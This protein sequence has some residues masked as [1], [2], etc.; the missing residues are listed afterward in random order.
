MGT[1]VCAYMHMLT[2]C[3]TLTVNL[4]GE[5][6][7]LA[8]HEVFDGVAGVAFLWSLTLVLQGMRIGEIKQWEIDCVSQPLCS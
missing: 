7:L 2:L 6:F 5:T 4:Q 3:M 8:S 1:H